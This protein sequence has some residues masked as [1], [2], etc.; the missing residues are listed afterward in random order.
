MFD[1][2]RS[3]LKYYERLSP[4]TAGKMLDSISSTLIAELESTTRDLENDTLDSLGMHKQGLEQLCFLLNWFVSS[5]EKNQ[6]KIG[7][8][9][10]EKPKR[11]KGAAKKKATR[12]EEW[13]WDDQIMSTLGVVNKVLKLKTGRLWTTTAERDA[14]IKSVFPLFCARN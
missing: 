3:L 7:G 5:A 2:Y 12:G 14:F 13:K 11:G 9:V 1:V 6:G 4:R 8:G 10:V